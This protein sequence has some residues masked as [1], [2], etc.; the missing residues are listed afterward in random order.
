LN[1]STKNQKIVLFQQQ[2]RKLVSC[3]VDVE[4]VYSDKIV[5]KSGGKKYELFADFDLSDFIFRGDEYIVLAVYAVG[6]RVY[7]LP[8]VSEIRSNPV[9]GGLGTLEFATLAQ[10][11]EIT[12]RVRQI[13]ELVHEILAILKNLSQNPTTDSKLEP[14]IETESNSNKNNRPRSNNPVLEV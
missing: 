3:I 8:V 7:P 5:L 14:E 1:N 9:A 11:P 2:R 4:A 13:D 12:E 6:D 10:S